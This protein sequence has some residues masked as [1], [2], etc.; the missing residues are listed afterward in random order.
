MALPFSCSKNLFLLQ[1]HLLL[2][3]NYYHWRGWFIFIYIRSNHTQ[4]SNAIQRKTSHQCTVF[5]TW[6]APKHY[7]L[8]P[9]WINNKILLSLIVYFHFFQ[10]SK[11]S[12]T[13]SSRVYLKSTA[14][15]LLEGKRNSPASVCFHSIPNKLASIP[16]LP[17]RNYLSNVHL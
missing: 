4:R 11:Y 13:T 3:T 10:Q 7:I 15:W 6:E 2:N 16:P 14:C 17:H 9:Q 5:I 1:H 12:S 8:Q